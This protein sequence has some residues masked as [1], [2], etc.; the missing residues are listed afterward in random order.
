MLRYLERVLMPESS[1][2]T[3]SS[4][5]CNEEAELYDRVPNRCTNPF[6]FQAVGLGNA[7]GRSM[8]D[9]QQGWPQ[10]RGQS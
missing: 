9:L 8:S 6:F 1:G 5:A 7:V 2:P 10:L 3:S 4:S